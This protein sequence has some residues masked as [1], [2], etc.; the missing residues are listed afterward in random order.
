M[1]TG[2]AKGGN[3]ACEN[4][5]LSS[6]VFFWELWSNVKYQSINKQQ[7]L[8]NSLF[9]RTTWNQSKNQSLMEKM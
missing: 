8:F 6:K 3:T 1:I 4:L 5:Q 2:S 7:H 9:S